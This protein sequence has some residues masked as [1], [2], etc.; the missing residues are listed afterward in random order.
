M[1]DFDEIIER[2]N[3]SSQ[4]WDM[5]PGG[6][7]LSDTVIPMWVADMD[8]SCPPKVI[9]AIHKA[10]D[11]KIFGYS[12]LSGSYME[13]VCEF[14]RRRHNFTCSAEQIV[15]T[16]GVV[17]ALGHAVNA[18]TEPGDG[19]IIQPPVYPPFFNVVNRNGRKLI[20]NRMIYENSTYRIDFDDLEEKAADPGTKMLIFCTPQ[21][22]SGR[23]W[24]IEE[25]TRVEDIC[26]RNGIILLCDEIHCDLIREGNEFHSVME[27]FYDR[28]NIICC[29]APSKTFNIAGLAAS[30]C[31][32]PNEEYR[33]RIKARVGFIDSNPLTTAA[34]ISAMTECDDWIDEMNAYV[35]GSFKLF[36]E[37]CEKHFPLA[38]PVRTEGTYLAWV[39]VTAYTDDTKALEKRILDECHVY[40]EC[41]DGFGSKGFLRVNL[42]CPRSYIIE[43]MERVS[44]LLN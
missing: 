8:L 21:N 13:T 24:T 1:Y 7:M 6:G 2:R 37:L 15:F 27:L 34:V 22:P 4:K 16:Q 39:D 41:G 5:A 10:A 36:Y 18:L 32:V 9:E 44:G 31:F 20:E 30:H 14:Y 19:I 26:L 43:A 25:L 42:G 12:Y 33:N 23:V 3:T 29:T 38:K 40:I 11:R 35:D 28:D 17:S